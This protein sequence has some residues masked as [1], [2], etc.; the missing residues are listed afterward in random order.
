MRKFLLIASMASIVLSTAT[1]P[2]K[3]IC[4]DNGGQDGRIWEWG[5]VGAGG[6]HLV[7]DD[8]DNE[9]MRV[10]YGINIKSVENLVSAAELCFTVHEAR[11][12]PGPLGPYIVDLVDFGP[13]MDRHDFAIPAIMTNLYSFRSIDQKKHCVDVA[14]AL[15]HAIE[16]PKKWSL[17]GS[18]QWF[19]VRIRPTRKVRNSR[20][21]GLRLG[22]LEEGDVTCLRGFEEAVTTYS[23][24]FFEIDSAE[25]KDESKTILDELFA[26][27]EKRREFKVEIGGHT[28]LTADERFSLKLSHRRAVAVRAYLVKK[29]CL[30]ARLKA[31]GYGSRYAPEGRKHAASNRRVTVRFYR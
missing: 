25:L 17:D 13:S 19:Q 3:E 20:L 16:N 30:A 4:V 18:S 6:A 1:Y 8:R 7:G 12:R 29:G 15:N 9:E 21:D 5:S 14:A 23:N 27:I 22:F 10:Y 2:G 26:V 11:G 24:I 31:R 28:A